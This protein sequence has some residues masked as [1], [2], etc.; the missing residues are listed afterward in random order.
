AGTK[1][2]KCLTAFESL[3]LCLSPPIYSNFLEMGGF[4]MLQRSIGSQK[5]MYLCGYQGLEVPHGIR[6]PYSLLITT[7]LF[8]YLGDGWFF[9]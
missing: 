5:G 9:Y 7:H 4:L 3:T 1:D 6:I 2:W 8:Q